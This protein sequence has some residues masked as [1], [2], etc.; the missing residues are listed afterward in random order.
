MRR[1]ITEEKSGVTERKFWNL[2]GIVWKDSLRKTVDCRPRS[3]V[4]RQHDPGVGMVRRDPNQNRLYTNFSGT[5][6]G[7]GLSRVSTR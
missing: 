1:T 5:Y 4:R 2:S 7:S 3:K 6:G